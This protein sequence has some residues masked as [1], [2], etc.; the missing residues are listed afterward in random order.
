[1]EYLYSS[2]PSYNPDFSHQT[3]LSDIS[4]EEFERVWKPRKH[5]IYHRIYQFICF[6]IFLGPIRAIVGISIFV[7]SLLT[8]IFIRTFQRFA[9]IPLKYGKRLCNRIANFGFHFILFAFGILHI[10]VNGKVDPETR[11]II[12]NHTALMDPFIVSCVHFV[13]VVMKIELSYNKYLA[14]IFENVD[15]VYVDRKVSRGASQQVIEHANNFN[16]NPV[17][18]FP[19]ATIN[20]GDHML[21][22]H[23]GA[24]LTPHKVQPLCIK[25]NQLLVPKGWN[26]YAWTTTDT[27]L[28]IW[29]LLSM[30]FTYVTVDLLPPMTLEKEGGGDPDKFAEYAQLVMANHFGVK[31]ITRSSAEI[32]KTKKE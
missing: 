32:F 27:A 2:S 12:A 3:K 1:M 5:T 7:I 11:I 25:Y 17:L 28:Y 29:E 26:Q 18:I 10:K 22:F 23:R 16:L 19:E 31:A 13:T 30:P 15:P 4:D 6:F 8:V 24:F 20:N 14:R 9:H 21:H